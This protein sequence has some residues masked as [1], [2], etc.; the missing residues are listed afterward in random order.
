MLIDRNESNRIKGAAILLML[1]LHLFN[2]MENVSLCTNFV[3]V[4]D[5]PLVN[6]LTRAA[7]PVAFFMIMSGYGLYI[8]TKKG[9]KNRFS[10]LVRLYINYWL[11]LIVFLCIGYFV[12]PERYP[13]SISEIV[14]N[15]TSLSCSYNGEYWFLFPY[16]V[17]ALCF[18][19]LL[20]WWEKWRCRYVLMLTFALNL[21]T[22]FVISR[23]GDEYLYNNKLLY[24]PFL[25]VHLMFS[26]ALGYA[27]ARCELFRQYEKIKGIKSILLLILLIAARCLFSTSVVHSLYAVL[28]VILFVN[29]PRLSIFDRV[30]ELLGIHS[31]NMWLIHSW[32]CYYLF[33]DLLY[34]LKYPLLIFVTL[35]IVSY[36]ISWSI[37]LLTTPISKTLFDRK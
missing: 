37:N 17:L 34:G 4:G 27:A 36:L 22:S 31:L 29:R 10:R 18:P 12:N 9:D 1:F 26:L 32:I 15:L 13:G 14:L 11:I 25:C 28:F 20:R 5:V 21:C 3:F 33:H 23:Y 7:N 6:V 30:L 35:V 8:V 24:N 19:L 2:R 16:V